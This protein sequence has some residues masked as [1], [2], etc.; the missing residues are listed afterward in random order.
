M[1][2]LPVPWHEVD[3]LLDR[4]LDPKRAPPAGHLRF[5]LED[6]DGAQVERRVRAL[7]IEKPGVARGQRFVE[8]FRARNRIPRSNE[9][10]G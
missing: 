10:R 3:P 2:A 6:V 1:D 4:L 8:G 9:P 7:G 5:A